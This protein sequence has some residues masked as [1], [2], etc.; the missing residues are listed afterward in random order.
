MRQIILIIAFLASTNLTAQ[1]EARL[2]FSNIEYNSMSLRPLNLLST[3]YA[4]RFYINIGSSV[5]RII[6]LRVDTIRRNS[7]NSDSTSTLIVTGTIQLIGRLYLPDSDSVI[8][9]YNKQDITQQRVLSCID[10]IQ[11][12]N[13][14]G[15]PSRETVTVVPHE[16]NSL[17][18]IE[19]KSQTR[20]HT[21]FF[22]SLYPGSLETDTIYGRI[23]EMIFAL[24]PEIK[25]QIIK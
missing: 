18:T 15:I 13:L 8:F 5:D 16:P 9:Y 3:N 20:Y 24:F 1:L 21:F 23:E 12:F 25:N 14:W 2:P 11:A 6:T 10:T 19:I 22:Y 7:S 4:V 17:Y